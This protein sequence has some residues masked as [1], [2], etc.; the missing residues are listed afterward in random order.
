PFYNAPLK[1][2]NVIVPAEAALIGGVKSAGRGWEMLMECLTLGRGISL[3]SVCV[4]ISQRI[5]RVVSCYS[6]IREQFGVPIGKFEGVE[7]KLCR[8]AGLT[9]LITATQNFTLSALN[10]GI[11]ASLPSAITKYNVT[12]RT[13]DIVQDGMDLMGGAGIVLGPRNLIAT[14]Y[15]SL[16]LAITVEGANILTRSFIIFGQGFLQNHPLALKEISALEKKD[17]STFDKAFSK[18]LYL[19]ICNIIRG[20]VLSLGRGWFFL[21]PGYFGRGHR[22]I[23]KIAWSA[24]L[25]SYLTNLFF[26]GFGARLKK[27]EKL[28]GRFADILSHQYIA[29]ALLWNW[30]AKGQSKNTWPVVQWGLN[31][32]FQQI[33]KA[34]EELL[35]NLNKPALFIP[36]NRFLYFLLRLNPLNATPS[37][38]LSKKV[39]EALSKN[40]AFREELTDNSLIPTNPKHPLSILE[41][42]CKLIEKAAP[43][44][45]KIKTAIRKKHLPRNP[46]PLLLDQALDKKIIT[47]EEYKNL[48][49]AE[50]ARETA[51]QVDTFTREE[52]LP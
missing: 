21:A 33:Q 19:I 32:C 49:E 45:N 25:F 22:S 6:K 47:S 35:L 39:T 37:D 16:P 34:L 42:T 50:Q 29:T 10:Q 18:H 1:G 2:R 38:K 14:A 27:K 5:V 24:A 30:R 44:A 26:F 36:L 48:K 7:E 4:G 41:Q 9:H 51:L 3:P 23:Q 40:N 8:M 20:M 15:T 31:Y 52:Y 46:I 28:S 11:S 12:E 13:R 43:A 17:L